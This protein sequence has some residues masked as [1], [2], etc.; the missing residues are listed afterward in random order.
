MKDC[1]IN[2]LNE[3]DDLL[4]LMSLTQILHIGGLVHYATQP[5]GATSNEKTIIVKCLSDTI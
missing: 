1:I 2:I 3:F 5:Y 4:V